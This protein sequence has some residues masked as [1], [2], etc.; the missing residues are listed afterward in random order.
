MCPRRGEFSMLF[1]TQPWTSLM[2]LLADQTEAA[3]KP[4]HVQGASISLSLSLSLSLLS[5]FLSLAKDGT[6]SLTRARQVLYH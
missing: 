1:M 6:Q 5:L 2:L 3:Q 4:T